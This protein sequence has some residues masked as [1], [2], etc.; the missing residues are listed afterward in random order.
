MDAPAP[1]VFLSYASED[2]EPA[3]RIRDALRSAGLEVW[4]DQSELRGGDAWDAA[5]RQRIG[6]CA[7]FV[8]VISANTEKRTEGYFRFEWKLAVD[9]SHRM[10]EDKT[11][12]LPVVLDGVSQGSP[13]VPDR[14]KEVQWSR[15]T[16]EATTAAFA[17]R[18]RALLRGGGDS[19]PGRRNR[20]NGPGSITSPSIAVLPFVNMSRDEENEYF[21]DGLAEELLNVLAGIRG[22]RVASRTSAFF[23]KGSKTDLPT[24]AR[25]LGVATILEGSVRKAGKRVRVTAQ[26][27]EVASDSH[28][29]S[30]TY[31]RDLDDIFAVQ[32]DIA[33]SVV[34][35]LHKALFPDASAAAAA[36]ATEVQE[37]S[38]GRTDNAEA[39]REYLQGRFF[40][41]RI[42][43]ADVERAITHFQRAVELDPDFA[44]AWAALGTAVFLRGLHGWSP[45]ARAAYESARSAAQRAIDVAPG[46]AEGHICMSKILATDWDWDGADAAIEKA[47]ALA[48]GN[49]AAH[50]AAA[51][52]A[53][54]R[55]RPDDAIDHARQ[56]V[57]LDP[58]SYAAHVGLG[59]RYLFRRR[60]D[61]AEDEFSTALDLNPKAGIVHYCLGLVRLFRGDTEGAL[62]IA[63]REP[64]REARLMVSVMAHHTLGHAEE[65]DRALEEFIGLRGLNNAFEIALLHAW[66]KEPDKAFEHLARAYAI[67]DADLAFLLGDSVLA[68]L[69]NDP[70][71]EALVGRMRLKG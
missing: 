9:R 8:P 1:A 36:A 28:L 44:L 54:S 40:L 30:R 37:A 68:L 67:R 18:A 43:Q 6:S 13:R 23:F 2:T 56:A 39:H 22:L 4:F 57:S 15:A 42:T 24:I 38:A 5:I 66:R 64:L 27:I 14:F 70:R 7:L 45:D 20:D 25:K 29:W 33:Q 52:R 12:L 65:S 11:F 58:L 69:R 63:E 17:E 34:T 41:E 60:L 53:A 51:I 35:E 48:P 46:I 10:S 47:L 16:D 31:D 3:R 19:Y 49:G 59:Q 55:G 21:A 26:L 32:D 62:A 61:E 50:R 71:W